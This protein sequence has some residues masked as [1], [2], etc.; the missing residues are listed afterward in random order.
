MLLV[1]CTSSM[2]VGGLRQS[3]LR[4]LKKRRRRIW[5]KKMIINQLFT[6]LLP[7]LYMKSFNFCI[8]LKCMLCMYICTTTFKGKENPCELYVFVC[9]SPEIPISVD[10]NI[11]L[12]SL[13]QNVM[14]HSYHVTLFYCVLFVAK[15]GKFTLHLF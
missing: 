13:G 2:L 5:K 8:I 6:N 12:C 10:F 15:L 14:T 9:V 7:K 1:F 4:M 3:H 11:F